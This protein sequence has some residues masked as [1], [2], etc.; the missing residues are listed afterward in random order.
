MILSEE[1]GYIKS[2]VYCQYSILLRGKDMHIRALCEEIGGFLPYDYTG[3]RLRSPENH[4]IYGII[5]PDM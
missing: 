3:F 1:D 2:C 5:F 4:L